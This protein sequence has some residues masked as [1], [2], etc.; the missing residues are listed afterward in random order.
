MTTETLP[1]LKSC[2]GVF[3][4]FTDFPLAFIDKSQA[5]ALPVCSFEF[6]QNHINH[7][8]DGFFYFIFP[9]SILRV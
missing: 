3:S 9:G 1:G 4:P 5:F 7:E 2:P 6:H 8:S